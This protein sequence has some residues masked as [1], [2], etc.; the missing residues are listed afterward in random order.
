MVAGLTLSV[1]GCV[2]RVQD[3]VVRCSSQCA[4]YHPQQSW[5]KV[6]FLHVSVILF[7]GGTCMVAGGVHGW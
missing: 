5:S 6:M 3:M 1:L 7:T 2:C 4:S